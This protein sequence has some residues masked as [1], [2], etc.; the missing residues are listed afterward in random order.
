VISQVLHRFITTIFP[1]CA[2]QLGTR[3]FLKIDGGPGRLDVEGLAEF[4]VVSY[5]LFPGKENSKH[6]T[7]KTDQYYGD[8]KSLS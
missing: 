3:V 6:I 8:F 2:D 5:Y 1:D 4:R 7:Q